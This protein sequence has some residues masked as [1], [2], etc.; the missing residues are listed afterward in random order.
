M[1]CKLNLEA[2]MTVKEPD[3]RGVSRS[4]IARTLQVTEGAVRYHLRRQAQGAVDGRAKVHRARP[5]HEAIAT[6]IAGPGEG[7]AVNLAAL[8]EWLRAEHDYVGSLRSIERYV[9]ATFPK[10]RLRARRRVETP[11]GAQGQ[12]DWAHFPAVRIYGESIDLYAL[13]L[14]LS[15][16]RFGAVIWSEKKDQIA[17]HH[18]H[19]EALRRIEGVPATIR[20]D[21]E[22]TAMSH[23]AGAW[24]EVN[25]AY[26]RYAHAVR[27]HVDPCPPRAPQ[28][29]G[30]IERRIRDHRFRAAIY[31]REWESVAELQAK[32]D[33]GELAAAQ[34]RLCPATGTSAYEAWLEEKPALTP[35]PLLPEPFDLVSRRGVALDCTV[36]FEGRTYS[37]PFAHVGRMVEVRG[38]SGKVQI[39]AD[40]GV[41]AEH[42]RGT[43][44]RVV[45]D[46]RHFEGDATDRVLPPAPLGRLGRRFEE[47]AALLPEQRP[48]DLYVA[49]AEA[50][51]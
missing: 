29:K 7:R 21:N 13:H 27:F 25:P 9:R 50:A 17:W 38:C 30:K 33:E 43:S 22:K 3:R 36:H 11:P 5:W 23:G 10:P 28:Y 45:L 47:I 16:S 44:Q 39:L 14:Q 32:T 42:R 26:E 1:A 15:F 31:A 37:V 12:V 24:G 19:N 46:P 6:W 35:L 48:L 8:H 51:R 18:T 20:I 40:G 4:A 49:L 2:R 41:I 34:R